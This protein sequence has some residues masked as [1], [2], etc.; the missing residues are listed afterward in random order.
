MP[1]AFSDSPCIVELSRV[2]DTT[3]SKTYGLRQNVEEINDL[4]SEINRSKQCFLIKTTALPPTISAV[5]QLEK[6]EEKR[7]DTSFLSPIV[8]LEFTLVL[9]NRKIATRQRTEA[10]LL[11]LDALFFHLF[12]LNC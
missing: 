5:P 10:F 7:R 6:M 1:G 4:L 11:T 3:R 9:T 8:Y 2:A 12:L